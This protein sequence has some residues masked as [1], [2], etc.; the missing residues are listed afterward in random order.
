MLL[1]GLKV[2]LFSKG[3]EQLNIGQGESIAFGV[4][5]QDIHS[6]M[7]VHSGLL[8]MEKA[9]CS[10][11][12]WVDGCFGMLVFRQFGGALAGFIS[13]APFWK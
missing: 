3:I 13:T 9:D 4:D 10:A 1:D 2:H 5:A 12:L 7:Y 11:S 8:E 6:R